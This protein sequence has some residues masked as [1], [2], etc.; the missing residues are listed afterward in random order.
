MRTASYSLIYFAHQI[1]SEELHK[2]LTLDQDW[3]LKK[4]PKVNQW[5]STHRL[6]STT[7]PHIRCGIALV[8][9]LC[10]RASPRIWGMDI[11]NFEKG[12][13]KKLTA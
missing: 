13:G 2:L 8:N 3:F 11:Q 1:T 5:T 9:E 7:V 4:S 6:T 10:V 12:W